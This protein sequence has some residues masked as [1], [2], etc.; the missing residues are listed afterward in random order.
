ML[1]IDVTEVYH[2]LIWSINNINVI[3]KRELS[4]NKNNSFKMKN[5]TNVQV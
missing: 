5:A 4:K 1:E 3:T 2:Q